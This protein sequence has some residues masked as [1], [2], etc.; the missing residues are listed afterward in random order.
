M[1]SQEFTFGLDSLD[2][3]GLDEETQSLGLD[4]DSY[5]DQVDPAP[6]VAGNYRIKAISLKPKQNKDG[7]NILAGG[8]FPIFSLGLVEIVDGLGEEGKT[9]K[10]GLF[11]DVSTQPKPRFGAVVSDL[12][13][14]TR[15]Y[16]TG[17]WS[18]LEA[19]VE[20]LREA[21]DAQRLFTAQ[22]DWSV[23]D[24][25]FIDAAREQLEIPQTADE[26]SDDDKKLLNAIY[27]VGRVTGMRFFPYIEKANRFSHVLSRRDM[28]F[29]N[30][31][32]NSPVTVEVD[33][34]NLEAR[35]TIVRYYSNMQF[36]QGSVRIGPI[37]T[38]PATLKGVIG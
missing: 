16:G 26:R 21:F 8:K 30:P 19:G 13:D 23:Y 31:V 37:K 32:T 20:A 34:R 24:K 9:R 36:E 38:K 27:K 28:T 35:P 3:S 5:Q 22:L 12:G 25:D 15:S 4:N 11:Q 29:T 18:G 17:N 1:E 2:F 10:L 6:P 14:L 7:E 33:P